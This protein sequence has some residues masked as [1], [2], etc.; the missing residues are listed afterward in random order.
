MMNMAL[1]LKDFIK[2]A[3]SM[4]SMDL[5][6][7]ECIEMGHIITRKG[8]IEKDMT[9]KGYDRMDLIVQVLIKKDITKMDITY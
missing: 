9:K 1:I 6:K 2:M 3:R 8:M 5:V 7:E 4:T